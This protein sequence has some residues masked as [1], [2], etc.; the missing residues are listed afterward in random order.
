[1]K[2]IE[3]VMS[4]E[5][6]RLFAD[7]IEVLEKVKALLMIPKLSMATTEQVAEY[8][9]VPVETIKS[10]LRRN[11]EELEANGSVIL[12]PQRFDSLKIQN[13][14]SVAAR[15]YKLFSVDNEVFTVNNNG[16]RFY[17]PR[18]IL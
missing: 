6:R 13:A 14:S 18:A 9:G 16:T 8:F 11:K 15:G 3:E 7:R 1:M 4:R 5:Q 12:T 10:T 17:S 2:R